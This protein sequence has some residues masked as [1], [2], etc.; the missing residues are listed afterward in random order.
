MARLAND[1]GRDASLLSTLPW[2]SAGTVA[3]A[4]RTTAA[5]SIEHCS[6]RAPAWMKRRLTRAAREDSSNCSVSMP[7]MNGGRSDALN[8]FISFTNGDCR[9]IADRGNRRCAQALRSAILVCN[10]GLR[11]ITCLYEGNSHVEDKT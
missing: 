2:A 10:T 8:I 7:P 1:T 6:S 4:H 11:N 3:A 9:L 5:K